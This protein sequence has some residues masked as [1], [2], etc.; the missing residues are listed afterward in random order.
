MYVDVH[1][2]VTVM[3][4]EIKHV[5]QMKVFAPLAVKSELA[6]E[7]IVDGDADAV[8]VGLGNTVTVTVAVKVHPSA[9]DPVTV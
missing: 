6:P 7:H 8:K 2:L 1:V 3:H 4:T 9:L 5:L